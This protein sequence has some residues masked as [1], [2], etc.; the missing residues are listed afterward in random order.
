MNPMM[1]MAGPQAGAM[2]MGSPGMDPAAAVAPSSLDQLLMQ[3]SG[4][5]AGIS[6]DSDPGMMLDQPQGQSAI[7]MLLQAL[8]GGQT[9]GQSIQAAPAYP[10]P[11]SYGM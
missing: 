2:P 9:L 11:A 8:L 4:P 5:G 1:A 3:M 6:T 10:T 7:L